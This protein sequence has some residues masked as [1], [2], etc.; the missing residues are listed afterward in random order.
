MSRHVLPVESIHPAIRERVSNWHR[1]TVEE[2]QGLL[3]AHPVVV[4]GMKQNPHCKR[5]RE[6]LDGQKIPH[7]YIEYGSY[8][9]GA[10]RQRLSLKMWTGWPTFPMCFFEGTFVGG[11]DEL[12]KLVEAGELDRLR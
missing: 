7:Q 2:V 9:P 3:H 1:R 8:L 4:V 11:A 6:L 12:G 10:W 5:A